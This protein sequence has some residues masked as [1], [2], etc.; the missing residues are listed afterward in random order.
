MESSRI[1][2]KK[3]EIDR[4]IAQKSNRYI[5]YTKTGTKIQKEGKSFVIPVTIGF[6]TENLKHILMEEEIF[7]SQFFSHS[8]FTCYFIGG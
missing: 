3:Q 1:K 7:Y 5:L 2:E 4:I 8:Y 6:S